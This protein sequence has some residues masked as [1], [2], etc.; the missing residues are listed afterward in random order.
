[1]VVL[2]SSGL[3]AWSAGV[4]TLCNRGNKHL[5][6][7]LPFQ[8]LA[9]SFRPSSVFSSV[10]SKAT[11]I[12]SQMAFVLAVLS[13]NDTETS[14]STT[15]QPCGHERAR[16][17]RLRPDGHW[18]QPWQSQQ[19]TQ[20]PSL[21]RGDAKFLFKTA[22]LYSIR[23][24]GRRTGLC[25][26]LL[27]RNYE[28]KKVKMHECYAI[29]KWMWKMTQTDSPYVERQGKLGSERGSRTERMGDCLKA[30]HLV[31]PGLVRQNK[32]SQKG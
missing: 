13:L 31:Q 8:K 25:G 17:D 28:T 14:A 20:R 7:K 32:W 22:A 1:M 18:R 29:L 10:P 11:Y 3:L 30:P 24:D 6:K 27:T 26:R 12:V 21:A 23:S 4:T 9:L 16:G 5:K 19:D 15:Q 2:L